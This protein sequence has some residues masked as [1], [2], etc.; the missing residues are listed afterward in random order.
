M[1][2][3]DRHF[4]WKKT[5]ISSTWSIPGGRLESRPETV[6][7]NREVAVHGLDPGIPAGMT[8]RWVLSCVPIRLADT[9]TAILGRPQRSRGVS[10]RVRACATRGRRPRLRC[11]HRPGLAT[12]DGT[13]M[14]VGTARCRVPTRSGR[15]GYPTRQEPPSPIAWGHRGRRQIWN[16][17]RRG[18]VPGTG[19]RNPGRDNASTVI[20]AGCRNP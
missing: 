7:G 14:P 9:M 18:T 4:P 5:E 2:L 1:S 12:S 3:T 13:L 6:G 17:W 20:P 15:S 16:D 19:S 8:A 10:P 11:G